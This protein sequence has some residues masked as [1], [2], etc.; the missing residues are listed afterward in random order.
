MVFRVA[1][2]SVLSRRGPFPELETHLQLMSEEEAAHQRFVRNRDDDL[3]G[4]DCHLYRLPGFVLRG[5]RGRGQRD[6]ERFGVFRNSEVQESPQP[7]RK[8]LAGIG[9]EGV[10]YI[11]EG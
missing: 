5:D 2:A 3:S 1:T 8:S 4:L 10:P 6:G 11:V 9:I 7:L